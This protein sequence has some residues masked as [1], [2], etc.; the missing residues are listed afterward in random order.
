MKITL[1]KI[2]EQ[3]RQECFSLKVDSAQSEY[4]TS[5]ENSLKD[6]QENVEVARPFAI[7]AD[8]KMIGFTMFAWDEN[9]EDPEDRYWL[10]RFMI[11]KSLQGKGY[12]HLALKEIIQYFKDNGADSIT[13]STKPSNK[14][15]LSLYHQ[16]GFKENGE[17]NDDEIILKLYIGSNS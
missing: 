3:N 16:F 6:A 4:I 15:A 9:Y 10:W 7:Y 17:M 12:G 11:D 14:V 2:T 1:K 13:L 5:N 8:D